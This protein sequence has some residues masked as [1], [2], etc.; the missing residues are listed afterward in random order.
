M[1]QLFNFEK[2]KGHDTT[3]S[4]ITFALYNLAKHP[5]VQQKCFNEIHDVFGT[6]KDQ[7][8]TLHALNQLSYLELTIKESLRLFPSV[9][10]VSRLAMDDVELSKYSCN[11]SS[12]NEQKLKM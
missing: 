11:L 9:P 6:D 3:T 4:G 12:F 1:I 5:D 10:I 8:S 7:S 2:F